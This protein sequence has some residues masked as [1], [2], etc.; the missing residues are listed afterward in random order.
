MDTTD[1]TVPIVIDAGKVRRKRIKDL[2]RGQGKLVAEVADAVE[3]VRRGLGDEALNKQ[4]VPVVLVY[5][6]RGSKRRALDGG[7][8]GCV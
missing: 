8:G 7:C 1:S 5:R 3:Q 6:R 4:F 2:K